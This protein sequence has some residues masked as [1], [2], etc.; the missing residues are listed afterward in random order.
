MISSVPLKNEAF[1][2]ILSKVYESLKGLAL[3]F[4]G[5]GLTIKEK[6]CIL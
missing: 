2:S 1:S 6:V 4:L 3:V 5:E